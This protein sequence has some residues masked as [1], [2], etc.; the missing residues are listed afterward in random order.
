MKD[1]GTAKREITLG[2][3]F[4]GAGGFPLAGTLAGIT[5]RWA[6]EIEPFPIRVTTK[7]FPDMRHIGNITEVSGAE[8][9]P[10]DIIT[11]GSPCQDLSV[12]NCGRKGLQGAR[13]GL[14][15]EA[16]RIIREM[17][18]KTNGRK[19]KFVVWENVVGAFSS[20]GGEDFRTVL[21]EIARI[22]D[23]G[24]CIPRY[25]DGRWPYS[26][27]NVG[28]GY[29]IAWR[30]VDAQFWG[31]PQRRRRIYLVAD[32]GGNRAGKIQFECD[33]L[34]G[35]FAAGAGEGKEAAGTAGG[36]AYPAIAR[37]LTARND[38]SPCIDRGPNIVIQPVTAVHLTQDPITSEEVAPCLST[39]NPNSG[40]ATVGVLMPVA[41][42]LVSKAS[43]AWKSGNPYSGCVQT[44]TAQTLDTS[45]GDATRNQ[46]GNLIV[47][48]ATVYENHGQDSRCKP[49]GDVSETV[50][51]KYGTG[52]NNTPLVV[53]PAFGVTSKGSGECFISAERH[54]TLSAGGGQAGQ[55]YPCVMQ[56]TIAIGRDYKT[57]EAEVAQTLTRSDVPGMVAQPYTIGNGQVHDLALDEK[58]RTLNCMHDAQAAIVPVD[59]GF[60]Y[61]V[62]RLMPLECCRLQGYPDFWAQNLDTPEPTEEEIDW[63][64]EVFET[65]RKAVKQDTKPKSRNQVRKWLQHPHSDSAECKM[66]GNSLAIPNAYHVLAGIAEEIQAEPLYIASWSGGKDSTATIIL[67]HEHGEP[68]DLIIFSE[69]MFDKEIS[70]ELPEHI[71]FVK[72]KAIPLFESWGY[73]V[74]I[75]H[76]KLNYMDI[77]MREPTRGKRAGMGMKTGFPM[78]G[79]CQVNRSAKVEP[80]EKFLKTIKSEYTQYIGIAVDE[81]K[82]LARLEGTNKISLLEK[83]GITERAAKELCENYG[84]LSPTYNFAPRGGCWFCPNARRRELQ[85]IRE[86]H[87]DL[88]KRLLDLEDVPN[89]IGKIWN[90]L[91][92]RSIHDW[93]ETF[94]QEEAQITLWDSTGKEE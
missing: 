58:A 64:C 87:P 4:D 71:D 93:E 25:P 19:P 48:N 69:V 15:L 2:S 55:G 60:P 83:Y 29:S 27:E 46:G 68:L 81:P 1:T 11:F 57:V 77:F 79:R 89:L 66:W 67:A 41:Y 59:S 38:G 82:R 23:P 39:G 51:A 14:F 20:N 50:V 21:E 72:N 85:N 17:R 65:H 49:M 90:S 91:E 9:E 13:S 35:N 88:W 24:V 32:F 53:Q 54:T 31:V 94:Q 86:N 36:G 34:C 30:T 76:A 26:G 62:R 22:K 12:A 56:P 7:R 63:W 33:R 6:S 78:S 43:N 61:I 84:L 8:I 92:R 74:K 44:E 80:I 37:S 70:G 75:L 47:G 40:Q 73:E 52:G 45:G 18:E 42:R 5:P 16:I 3:L 10:V 28:D